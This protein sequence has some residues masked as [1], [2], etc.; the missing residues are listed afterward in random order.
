MLW[1]EERA[2]L[3]E[4]KSDAIAAMYFTSGTTGKARCVMLTHRNM[5]SQISA[6]AESI[7]LSE[8]DV[9]R[10]LRPSRGR[11]PAALL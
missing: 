5:G 4:L 9:D 8:S 7:P 3:P 6:I 2:Y 11:L 10:A 1:K